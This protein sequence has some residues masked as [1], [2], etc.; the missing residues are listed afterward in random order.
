MYR[1]S[2]AGAGRVASSLCMEFFG[3]GFT[4]GKIVSSTPSSGKE[5]ADSCRAEWSDDLTFDNKTDIIIVAVPD[6]KL[7]DVLK[8]IRRSSN[9]V[10][11]HTAGSYGQEV[12]PSEI[13]HRGV[14]YPLQTFTKGRKI[15]YSDL[16]FFIEASDDLTR[17]I[18]ITL[19]ETVGGKIYE[20]DTERRKMLHLAAVFA[21][22]FTNHMLTT[23]EDLAGKAGFELSVL[24][25]LIRETISK[26]FAD[27]P[28]KS[29][30]GP[31]SRN[32]VNTMNKHLDLL[33]SAP[34]LQKVYKVISESIINKQTR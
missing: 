17:K 27:G 14:L 3:K 16:P 23:G 13:I 21:C 10:V 4:I 15:N 6:S 34:E 1:I 22:N 31:A 9:T 7:D 5:L 8:S 32:D 11:V 26:A 28:G 29:Q 25:T 33:S 24:E 18:L 19:I 20:A 30:T 12:F 2:F